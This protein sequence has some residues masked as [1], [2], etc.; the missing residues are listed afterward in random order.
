MTYACRYPGQHCS[1]HKPSTG[2]GGGGGRVL[3]DEGKLW[4]E[5]ILAAEVPPLHT[6][7][8]C[9]ASHTVVDISS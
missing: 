7:S 4:L 9:K 1:L 3:S 5:K 2:E 6:S 8:L